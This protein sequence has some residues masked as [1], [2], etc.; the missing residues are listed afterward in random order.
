MDRI[1]TLY[2]KPKL[3]DIVSL[4]QTGKPVEALFAM[5][6]A[7]W[8]SDFLHGILYKNGD[9]R[10]LDSRGADWD[11]CR[12]YDPPEWVI[13]KPDPGEGF[14][15]LEKFPDEEPLF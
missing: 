11:D 14:R 1:S 10:W 4:V 12:I 6:G 5:E 13:N 7:A 15:L 9:F 2:R 8:A 3:N